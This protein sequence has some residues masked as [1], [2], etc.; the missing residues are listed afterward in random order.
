MQDLSLFLI[1]YIIHVADF[2]KEITKYTKH[3]EGDHYQHNPTQHPIDLPSKEDYKD[4]WTWNCN[5]SFDNERQDMGKFTN[6]KK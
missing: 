3:A 1:L 6:N 2:A 5:D 4:I